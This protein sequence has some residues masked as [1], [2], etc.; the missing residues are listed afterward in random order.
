MNNKDLREFISNIIGEK[1]LSVSS[2]EVKEQL[3]EDMTHR[4]LDLIDREVISAMS[5]PNV[6]K[7]NQMLDEGASTDVV[8]S[9]IASVV[10]NMQ[11]IVAQTTIR[12]RKA[13][14]NSE[15]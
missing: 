12:F 14:L 13:Y 8:Q 11:Q 1:G 7:L 15:K 5:E 10:P 9:F 2:E 4:L 6:D 3:I